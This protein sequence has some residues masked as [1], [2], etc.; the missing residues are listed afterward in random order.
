[1]FQVTL[2]NMASQSVSE[3]V[4]DIPCL[5]CN[6]TLPVKVESIFNLLSSP[7]DAT[8]GGW[9]DILD[10]DRLGPSTDGPFLPSV[11][12]LLLNSTSSSSSTLNL[13]SSVQPASAFQNSQFS[14]SIDNNSVNSN[15]NHKNVEDETGWYSLVC[16]VRAYPESKNI[17]NVTDLPVTEQVI[18]IPLSFVCLF[19]NL[20]ID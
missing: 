18:Q 12:K 3:Y 1:M 2:P 10:S 14:S 9:I 19:I 20:F 6:K 7:S 8:Q 5:A 11:L 13:P 15:I 4:G 16:G 17:F